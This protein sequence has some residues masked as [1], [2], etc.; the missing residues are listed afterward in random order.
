MIDASIP[1]WLNIQPDSYVKALHS[2]MGQGL[3]IAEA[4][5]RAEA[6]QAEQ[7]Q[8]E[9]EMLVRAW[10]T[11][12]RMAMEQ[13]SQR[14][15]QAQRATEQAALNAYREKQLVNEGRG[16]DLR[17]EIERRLMAT[18]NFK[19]NKPVDKVTSNG[20]II[21]F[22]PDGTFQ[23]L[24]PG[25]PPANDYDTVIDVTPAVPEEEGLPTTIPG[26][27]PWGIAG[28]GSREQIIPGKK[29]PAIPKQ[30]VI[31]RIP[32]GSFGMTKPDE[33]DEEG[34]LMDSPAAGMTRYPTRAIANKFLD[35]AGGDRAKTIEALKAAGYDPT[36]YAD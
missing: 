15:A 31:H 27:F 4:Q 32:R 19:E 7:A 34:S 13:E 28:F 2:G 29:T 22:N 33:T 18:Q 5:N 3:A 24:R 10:E 16:L 25:R 14:E 26:R 9:Q 23:Q 1:P 6:V 30:T 35:E 17:G 36:K 8:R 12:Q 21:R 20:E 11:Q